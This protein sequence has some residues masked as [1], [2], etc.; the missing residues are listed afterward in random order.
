MAG[1]FSTNACNRDG[2]RGKEKDRT[3]MNQREEPH[4]TGKCR[5]DWEM[6]EK[7]QEETNRESFIQIRSKTH[8][9]NYSIL[10]AVVSLKENINTNIC[11][12]VW[13]VFYLDVKL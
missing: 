4:K 10:L 5:S 11:M 2:G 12:S 1:L 8:N 9:I 7:K 3:Q 6:S 13:C